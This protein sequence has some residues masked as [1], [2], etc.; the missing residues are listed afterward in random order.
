MTPQI[1]V[2]TLPFLEAF[3]RMN[4]SRPIS[5]GTPMPI[6]LSE[7]G[8]YLGIYGW[9]DPEE[10]VEVIQEADGEYLKSV[11]KKMKEEAERDKGR[12]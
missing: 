7:I 4:V 3:N 10:L 5:F 11:R 1:N 2:V 6:P 8:A 9:N 12:K